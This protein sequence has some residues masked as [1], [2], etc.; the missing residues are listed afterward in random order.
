MVFSLGLGLLLQTLPVGETGGSKGKGGNRGG[1]HPPAGPPQA[2]L[3]KLRAE[4]RGYPGR[5]RALA[6]APFCAR[7]AEPHSKRGRVAAT[8]GNHARWQPCAG[9]GGERRPASWD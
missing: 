3:H 2:G 4:D 9:R 5:R 6:R 8:K 7:G 1:A